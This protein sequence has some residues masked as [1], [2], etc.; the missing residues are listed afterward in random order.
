MEKVSVIVTSYNHELYIEQCIKSIFKQ[1]HTNIE[2]IIIDDGSKDS[3]PTLLKNLV[4][5][6]PFEQTKLIIQENKGACISRNKG[7]DLATGDYILMVDSDNFLD[8]NYIQSG[9][10]T[11]RK[12]GKDIA[13]FS[14]KS[15]ETGEIIN[16]V[17][18]FNIDYFGLVNFIDTCAVIRSSVINNHRFDLYLNRLFMQDYDFFMGLVSKG[19]VP[20][21]VNG[22]YLNYRVLP[23]SV[24]NL[25]DNIE[26]RK[27]WFEVYRYIKGKYPNIGGGLTLNLADSFNDLYEHYKQAEQQ[28]NNLNNEIKDNLI[29]IG[30]LH[31]QVHDKNVHIANIEALNNQILNSKIW[32]VGRL[33]TFPIR[34]LK[35]LN[36]KSKT[37]LRVYRM[38]GI[39]GL[40]A[41]AKHKT[42]PNEQNYEVSFKHWL[43]TTEKEYLLKTKLSQLT[44]EYTPL[45]SILIPVYNVEKKWLEK[46]IMSI[47]N[48]WY[49]NWEICIADDA[50][51]NQETIDY[52]N[53]LKNNPKY[54]IVFR[55]KNGHISE[56]TNSALEIASGDY[57]ALVD[58]DDTLMPNALYEMVAAIN[59]NP[60]LAMI[61]SDED[62]ID[63]N[64]N[65]FDAHFKPDWSPSLILNQNYVSH[66]GVYKT[67]IS[68]K[69]GGFRKGFE[70]CQD[71]DFVLRFTEQI[72]E[73]QIK[74]IPKILY[75]WRAIS[76]ST[77]SNG[78]Q[79][80]YAFDNGIRM[81]EETLDRRRI[82]GRVSRGKY[83]GLYN[84]EYDVIGNPLVSII[85]PTRNGFDDLK[86]CV[87]SI[88]DVSTYDNYEI[89]IA[90]NGSDDE[91]VL[92]L[93]NYYKEK[94]NTKFKVVRL[95]MPFNYSRI[96]NLAALEANGSYFLF[97]N[98]DTTVI[99]PNWIETMLSFAQYEKYGCIGAKLWYPDNTIQHGGVVLG[100][101][102][103]AGHSFLNSTKDD[104]G[105]FS[106][107]YTDY[108]YT[109][110]TA[111]C[112]MISKIDFEKV[113]GFDEN[114]EVAFNDVDLCIRVHE[115]GRY[116]VWAHNVELYHYESKSRGLEDTPEK[117]KRFNGEI[118]KMKAKHSQILQN[119]PAYN[120]NLSLNHAPF[121]IVG[122]EN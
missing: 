25:G 57:I 104:P 19:A 106:R 46:C 4:E 93:F 61:Y 96:N 101:G 116:N 17:P 48:Q 94:L 40:L 30:K 59:E 85:I 108:N 72:D 42:N 117:I 91:N 121:T 18:E 58:N 79:K 24:G 47:E 3:S 95:D 82:S 49:D 120:I 80:D 76:S 45:I 52:L 2:L 92:E 81:I 22:T 100:T 32:F 114:L 16:D 63:E 26:K 27:E 23:N 89:V 83:P 36:R 10:E 62:K 14:L 118:N 29:T 109:A 34:K 55:E 67:D 20:V 31:A 43:S 39:R 28:V 41:A 6:S 107:L 12:T 5:Q 60:D 102:G 97:L 68:R 70:G 73:K 15:A 75:H 1:T 78:N 110:V 44:F 86:K 9:V 8:E 56:A 113:K 74:H 53:T 69:I 111:A 35:L 50:S 77:A 115:L 21:K 105:Y 71:H 90:D 13:Y 87:D 7:L 88:I 119:D 54:K 64:E 38:S 122:R 112:L 37:A 103:V 99:S 84:V 65:R 51:T 11:L 98:N 33:V 66:L